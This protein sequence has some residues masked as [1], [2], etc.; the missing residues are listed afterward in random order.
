[1]H[2]IGLDIHKRIT[3]IQHMDQ[4]GVLGK[5][6]RLPTCQS[7]L[8]S[9]V[10]ELTEPT[11]I[12]FEASASYW[13]ISQLLASHPNVAELKV[14]DPRRSR[15]LAEELSVQRGYGRA[16]N[17]RIDAEMLA[18][19]HRLGLA[20]AIHLPTDEQLAR[21]T[22]TRHRSLLVHLAT[23]ASNQIQALLSMHGVALSTQS[24]L[25]EFDRI[26]LYFVALPDYVQFSILQLVDQLRLYH[27]QVQA[28]EEQL[29]RILPQSAPEMGWL[30]SVPGVGP[31]TAR[32]ILSEILSIERFPAPRYL[33]SY[34]GLAP[35]ERESAGK[36]GAVRLNRHC[37]Y[38]LK[39]AL[40]VAAHRGW[41]H[42]KYRRKY[43][44]DVKRKGK[45]IAKF[46]LA[47]RQARA[48]YW[49]LTRQQ[50]FQA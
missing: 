47:R 38:H 34:A 10:E 11:A 44:Q 32:I 23:R 19:L 9:L 12:C 50:P 16:K 43:E 49:M 18:E 24:L 33:I 4:D 40:M 6:Q 13:W 5:S 31:V 17:D 8:L 48:I 21:R 27:S 1:M 3:H 2:Y 41:E 15:K 20:P 22:L 42:P 29:E 7:S 45:M 37:N 14:V 39:Y 26:A 25:E 30:L 36:Q 28:C 46:N 35:V